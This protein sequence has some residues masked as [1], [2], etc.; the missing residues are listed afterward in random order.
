V[1]DVHKLRIVSDP[2][3]HYDLLRFCQ[4]THLAF[5][6]RNVPPDAMMRTIDVNFDPG[7]G[8]WGSR[9][10]QQNGFVPASVLVQDSIVL[11]IL[12]RGLGNTFA[13]QS[14]QELAWCRMIVE[15]PH[16]QGGLGITPLP[17]SGMAAFYSATA[18]MVSW[19]GSLPHVSQ[20]AADQNLADPN[21]WKCSSL[22]TL[23][24]LHEKLKT[25]YNCAEWA[26]PPA[27]D[28]P[29]PDAPAQGRDDDSARPLSLP[30]LN[31][32]ASLRARQVEEN[33]EA[34]ARPSLPAQR[35][36]TKR[37]M[38]NWLLH[39][40]ML[41]NPPTARMLDV[42]MLHHTQSVPMID[43]NSALRGNMP[44][45]NDEEGGNTPR[46]S[47]SP[48]SSVWGQM[49]RPWTTIGHDETHTT[50]KITKEDYVAFFHHFFGFTNNPALAPFA[51]VQCPCQRYLMGGDDAWDHINS[52][53]H[54]SSNW[55]IAH[56]LS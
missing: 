55:T 25:H 44:Q 39:Q 13:T 11:A 56:E 18:Q 6:A 38:Q 17:S 26:P 51:N 23:K 1:H 31:L 53:P 49:G 47:F 2:K 34:A 37:I 54:H 28:A 21:T 46:L 4:H 9:I 30:P 41:R 43:E 52:C 16:H 19:L 10:F 48:A 14:V 3:I 35:Q 45:R 29:A 27:A 20:W 33:G 22:K 7:R 36:V 32:L 15:L 42:H 50:E 8:D 12:Q 24:Q 40:Q 5:L